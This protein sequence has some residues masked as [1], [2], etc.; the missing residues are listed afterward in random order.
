MPS[1]DFVGIRQSRTSSLHRF[2]R[3]ETCDNTP[4]HGFVILTGVRQIAPA[5][6]VASFVI[7]RNGAIVEA[8]PDGQSIEDNRRI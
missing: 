7:G 5:E 8:S 6:K 3:R 2:L 1:C 4:D